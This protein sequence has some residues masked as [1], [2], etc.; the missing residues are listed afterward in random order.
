MK[1]QFS[2]KWDGP[3]TLLSHT[4][5]PMGN[6]DQIRLLSRADMH[7]KLRMRRELAGT[8]GPLVRK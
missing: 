5:A 3:E 8:D 4:W 2:P 6:V 1:T 7:A